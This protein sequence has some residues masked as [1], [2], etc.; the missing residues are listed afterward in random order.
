[1]NELT[2]LLD[3]DG[4]GT[5]RAPD[6]GEV[7]LA[8][9]RTIDQWS[10]VMELA[11][12]RSW[13][14]LPLGR[15]SKLTW[16]AP[17]KRV[18]LALSTRRWSG[19]TAYEPGDGTLTARSGSTMA[20]LEETCAG[21][22][23]HLSPA[24]PTPGDA[25]LGGVLAAG[26]SGWDRLRYGPGR[27]ALLGMTVLQADGA[28]TRSGGALVKNV[29]GYDLFRLHCGA[30]GTLGVILEA[31]LRLYPLP[32]RRVRLGASFSDRAA[33]LA[34]A[35]AVLDLDARPACVVVHD[36]DAAWRTEVV[37]VGGA[38][39]VAWER[40]RITAVIPGVEE[41]EGVAPGNLRDLERADGTWPAVRL[42]CRP[43]HLAEA[44]DA[45][46]RAGLEAELA[47]RVV[48]QPGIATA[49]VRLVPGAE[50]EQVER[51]RTKLARVPARARWRGEELEP[52]PG[53]LPLMQRL[54][55]ALDAD[56]TLIPERL[57]A[58]L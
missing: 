30:F 8:A 17:A 57:H 45:V 34:G 4:I 32:A 24:V 46:E 1:M 13:R 25:T 48:A 53:A 50:P 55:T 49:A 21:G 6:G 52:P 31:S 11:A 38:E 26:Q 28:V 37:L 22:G 7:P 42:D 2:D 20:E 47:L 12:A 33:A 51:F 41:V 27:H 3:A 39:V 56:G 10:A 35:R 9:P 58:G 14:V 18:D 5:W 23:H 29:T 40:E 15:G 43:S 44:L 16:T 54:R 19:A 36:R